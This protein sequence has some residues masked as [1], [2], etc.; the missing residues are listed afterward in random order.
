MTHLA[1]VLV[2]RQ[3][4]LVPVG[5]GVR[6]TRTDWDPHLTEPLAE[7]NR[8]VDVIR[9]R[10]VLIEREA[11]VGAA[12]RVCDG[13]YGIRAFLARDLVYE[14]RRRAFHGDVDHGVVQLDLPS[15]VP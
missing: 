11:A 4:R 9:V 15:R 13:R 12:Q 8:Q 10:D 2:S 7:L 5:Q 14:G 1:I 6:V 3:A